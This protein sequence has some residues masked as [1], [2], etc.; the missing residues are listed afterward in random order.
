M[1]GMH[2]LRKTTQADVTTQQ[3][4]LLLNILQLL[5]GRRLHKVGASS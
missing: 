1:N 3:H 5:Y 2:A 4:F